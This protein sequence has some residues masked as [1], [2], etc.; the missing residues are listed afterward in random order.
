M[1]RNQRGF[2]LPELLIT[3]VISSIVVAAAFS[4]YTI[5]SN[6]YDYQ[7]DMKYIS[8]SARKVVDII[9][10][11]VRM[12]GYQDYTGSVISDPVTVIDCPGGVGCINNLD[13]IT[14]VYDQSV[15][16][17]RKITYYATAYP[18]GS[19][20]N[21]RYRL[22]KKLET[23]TPA[24][25]NAYTQAYDEPVADY[26][27]DLQFVGTRGNCQSGDIK[28]G[29]GSSS[30]LMTPISAVWGTNG[31]S[32]C[33]D[34]PLEIFDGDVSTYWDCRSPEYNNSGRNWIRL[35]FAEDFRPTKLVLNGSLGGLSG[36][37]FNLNLGEQTTGYQSDGSYDLLG[38]IEPWG[39]NHSIGMI[40]RLRRQGGNDQD[41]DG[42]G[43]TCVWKDNTY[44]QVGEFLTGNI[45]SHMYAGDRGSSPNHWLGSNPHS[46][47]VQ[48][49]STITFDLEETNTQHDGH[50][51]ATSSKWLTILITDRARYCDYSEGH[52]DLTDGGGR[53]ITIPDMQIYGESFGGAITPS[54]VETSVLIRSPN[55]HGNS[56]RSVGSGITLGNRT[57]IQWNDRYL[58]DWFTSS[59]VIRNVHYQSQ[60]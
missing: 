42:D 54:E 6:S 3:M 45:Y 8:Q 37:S 36:G 52:C 18:A 53:F 26:I 41:N 38:A 51:F 21:D 14:I 40:F 25:C 44:C 39:T 35:T 49:V 11:D 19:T 31:S 50:L 46:F 9:N 12:A 59:V 17:R 58:R 27:E 2:T 30:T 43:W 24:S 23:C 33:S 7:N 34:N 13:Q 1:H 16:E 56:E 32:T 55:E 15:N 47:Q 4:S 20:A 57:D 48:P 28:F 29:C 60:M 5:I 10:E 22:M